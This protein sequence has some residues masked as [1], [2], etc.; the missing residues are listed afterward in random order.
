[1]NINV[2]CTSLFIVEFPE[3][4]DHSP[5]YRW[6]QYTCVSTSCVI[7]KCRCVRGYT[8]RESLLYVWVIDGCVS[9]RG[10]RESSADVWVINGCVS[11]RRMCESS[12]DVWV[13][14]GCVS[15]RGK[16]ESSREV[17]DDNDTLR[18]L[19]NAER[20]IRFITSGWWWGL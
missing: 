19:L 9:H 5:R 6:L 17:F 10:K 20:V 15:H 12:R 2:H 14:D 18:L 3:H 16:R 1:M 4:R 7:F 13:I 11:H 8:P